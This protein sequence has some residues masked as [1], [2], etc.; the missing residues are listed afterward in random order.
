MSDYSGEDRC[1]PDEIL[2]ILKEI[3]EDQ[4]NIKKKLF[5]NGEVGLCEKVRQHDDEL[6]DLRDARKWILRYIVGAV[7][8]SILALVLKR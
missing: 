5:G 6:N 4:I 1:K 3:R 2:I 8:A 7:L